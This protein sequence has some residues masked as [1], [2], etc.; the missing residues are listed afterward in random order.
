MP[1]ADQIN[2]AVDWNRGLK[3]AWRVKLVADSG[4]GA[5]AEM[6]QIERE[7]FCTRDAHSRT[8]SPM[9][10]SASM[11]SGRMRST[12]FS[13]S[14]IASSARSNSSK[15]IW[16]TRGLI[17]TSGGSPARRERVRRSCMMLSEVVMT[18]YIFGLSS[19]PCSKTYRPCSKKLFGLGIGSPMK[20]ATETLVEAA[21]WAPC[22]GS[23]RRCSRAIQL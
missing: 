21:I 23:Q 5:A 6:V 19:C 16:P 8:R 10:W 9:T 7:D 12:A 15:P 17:C 4:D 13:P 11:S 18:P 3:L 14:R 1:M 2:R 20:V 22:V